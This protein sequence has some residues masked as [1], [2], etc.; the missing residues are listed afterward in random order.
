MTKTRGTRELSDKSY[1]WEKY[2]R[3]NCWRYCYAC[4]NAE[5]YN[6]IK[7]RKEWG[8]SPVK[9]VKKINKGWQKV[10]SDA[11]RK[12]IMI[13][14]THDL[15]DDN[16]DDFLTIAKK[17]LKAGHLL[18]VTSKMRLS[19]AEKIAKELDDWKDI[20]HLYAR[21]YEDEMIF[22]P[23]N[24]VE[25]MITNNVMDLVQHDYWQENAP[26]F[27]EIL[28]SLI[29]LHSR[30]F[31]TN[32]IIEPWLDKIER[33]PDL[34]K[35]MDDH[36]SG[37]IWVGPMNKRHLADKEKDWDENKWGQ[38]AIEKLLLL[39][40]DDDLITHSKIRYKDHFINAISKDFLT[41]PSMRFSHL[42]G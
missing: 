18:L 23:E 36:V 3:N 6:Q 20:K 32:V 42:G 25:F 38:K 9:H 30:G 21:G 24:A 4:S 39:I 19:V 10:K 17:I 15:H 12:R 2:C 7:D 26:G 29:F 5:R 37:V 1:N 27:S 8:L 14:T 28:Q 34:I 16:V 40:E 35:I 31:F 33:V 13:P 41:C 22:R 11:D